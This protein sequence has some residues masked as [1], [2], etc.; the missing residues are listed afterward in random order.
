MGERL[1]LG[2]RY[3]STGC[4][5]RALLFISFIATIK[6]LSVPDPIL[7]KKKSFSLFNVVQFDNVECQ[8]NIMPA[9]TVQGTCFTESECT[10]R[11]GV[12]SGNCASGFGVCCFIKVDETNCGGTI[13]NNISYIENA[14]FP[15]PIRAANG[16]N[17]NGANLNCQFN[18]AA[19]TNICQIRLDFTSVDIGQ[20]SLVAN[21]VGMCNGDSITVASPAGYPITPLCGTLT[22]THM[23]V[24]TGRNNGLGATITIQTSAAVDINRSWRIRVITLECETAWKAPTDCLQYLTGPSNSFRSYNFGN[25]MIRNLQYDVC[26]RP[27]EGMCQ[28]QVRESSTQTDSFRLSNMNGP[29]FTTA[30]TGTS[31]NA[32]K[33][34]GD[35][36][37][38]TGCPHQ[39][40]VVQNHQTI[41]TIN[42]ISPTAGGATHTNLGSQGTSRFCGDQL[43]LLN[44]NTA[45]GVLVGD[46]PRMKVEVFSAGNEDPNNSDTL[47]FDLMYTQIPCA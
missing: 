22:G 31:E 27:E 20:P 18:I 3:F 8:T 46:G 35:G 26:I 4:K 36:T 15:A 41:T 43:N 42:E 13:S 5:M 2:T 17:Q 33:A 28:F 23:Y 19:T 44:G 34:N 11:G 7:R 39:F 38:N 16:A 21:S 32:G 14:V 10:N 1:Q 25:T 40:I 12:A 9:G 45:S 30:A 6:A 24:E 47:G 37:A 29:A